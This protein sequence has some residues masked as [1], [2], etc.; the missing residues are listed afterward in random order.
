MIFKHIIW[1]GYYIKGVKNKK[2][3]RHFSPLDQSR[4]E[5]KSYIWRNLIN[6]PKN[7]SRYYLYGKSPIWHSLVCRVS[8][9]I[10]TFLKEPSEDML[11]NIAN[12]DKLFNGDD[13][14]KK[15]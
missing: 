5:Q 1:K 14:I 8:E 15:I 6:N 10:L 7:E 2:S 13:T 9:N 3:E 11:Q 4:P 12:E